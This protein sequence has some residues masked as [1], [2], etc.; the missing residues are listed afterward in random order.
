MRVAL[1]TSVLWAIFKDE[2]LAQ[3]WF[4]L[5]VRMRATSQFLVCEV[6]F[7]ELAPLFAD[8]LTLEKHF[9]QLGIAYDSLL[10]ETAFQ[11]GQ[12]FRRYRQ[13]GGPRQHLIPDFLVAAHASHQ[14]D[15][16]FAQDRGYWRQYFPK[17][18]LIQP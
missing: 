8:R 16:L 2:P 1:D 6:V 10:P 5:L 4:D 18:R 12:I 13:L 7:A 14:A 17:L 3:S 9:E 15:G 11:A